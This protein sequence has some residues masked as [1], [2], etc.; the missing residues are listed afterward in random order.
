MFCALAAP[1]QGMDIFLCS[2]L[3]KKKK[4][5]K[6][7]NKK[8]KKVLLR[9][10]KRHTAR[11]VAI[12]ISCYSGGGGGEGGS[13][14]KKFFFQSEHV[15]SQIWC[16]K[17]FPLLVGGGGPSTK[18]FFF[19][20]EH[21]SS[22]IW[23]QKIFPLLGGGGVG[24]FP[25]Q[26][27][28]L[29]EHISSQIWCQKI[30]PLLGGGVGGPS[31]KFF[32][33]VWTCIKPNLVSKIFPLYWDQ[34]PPPPPDLRLDEPTQKIWDLRPPS[35]HPS[36][37][38][39]TQKSETWD[40][41]SRPRLDQPIPKSE[42]WDPPPPPVQGWISLSKNLRPETPP[43]PVQ[44]WISLSK[45]LRPGTPPLPPVN[46]NRQTPLKQYL[47]VVLRT[48][49]VTRQSPTWPQEACRPWHILSIACPGRGGDEEGED[50]GGTLSWS[51]WEVGEGMVPSWS[52]L[53]GG[54]REGRGRV[55][56]GG[57]LTGVSLPSRPDE[58]TDKLKTLPSH[59]TSYAAGNYVVIYSE[60]H[61]AHGPFFTDTFSLETLA[62]RFRSPQTSRKPCAISF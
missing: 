43:P 40:P 37:D 53:K 52:W 12:A 5:N 19:Q 41:P 15:S 17:I 58:Q 45:N 50:Q 7:K 32:F 49:A 46:V 56:G 21:V 31:T 20:S 55:G 59:S 28:F 60:E 27:F 39:P 47:P 13:L 10:R 51:W 6:I 22:Q 57:L 61:F 35:P 9:E 4:K 3:K 48:R 2:L 62:R 42:T 8:N 18:I 54:C 33:P 24:E 29:S 36:L 44:G 26:K 34:D 1:V 38:Q 11:R 30:F 25:W 14:D 16:Q 23:C